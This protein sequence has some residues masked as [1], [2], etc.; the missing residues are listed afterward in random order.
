MRLG[1]EFY[2]ALEQFL[3][4]VQ[5]CVARCVALSTGNEIRISF[6]IQLSTTFLY[7]LDPLQPRSA[8][9]TRRLRSIFRLII[10]SFHR[11]LLANLL[12]SISLP[13]FNGFAQGFFTIDAP[14][15]CFGRNQIRVFHKSV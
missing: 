10:G 14:N 3:S 2:N 7:L 1:L 13:Y 15:A 12:L 11:F 6:D 5:P 8:L 4:A 9:V